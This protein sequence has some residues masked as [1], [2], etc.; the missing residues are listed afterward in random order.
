MEPSAAGKHAPALLALAAA[1]LFGLSAPLS[2]LLLAGIPP[3]FL[4]AFLYLGAGLGML[5]LPLLSRENRREAP[6]SSREVPWVILMVLLDV[7]APFLLLR[8]L[9]RTTAA[10]ASLLFNFETVAT[11]LVALL[12][13]HEAIGKRMWLSLGII[14]AASILLSIDFSHP[15]VWDFS[16]GSLLVL[17][18]CGCWGMENN[19]TR[20]MSAKSPAQIVVVKGVGAGGT[21]LVLAF[22]LDHPFPRSAAVIAPA[23]L[24]GFVSYGLS[25]FCYVKAQRYLGAVRTS[26]YYAAAPFIGVLLSMVI[27]KEIPSWNF[28]AAAA[29]MLWG[30]RLAFRENHVHRHRHDALAHNHMHLHDDLHHGHAH[31]PPVRG[32]H[33]HE[34]VH[35]PCIHTHPHTPDLHH[36]HRHGQ[37]AGDG[38]GATA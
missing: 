27:L 10:N 26:A 7:L 34:H 8:G 31:N 25:I 19:C 35:E 21:A 9:E 4:T 18:A 11:S 2:K 20:N 15:G 24:L 13:F 1:L 37:T 28:A 30:V 22:L 23:L 3:M 14:T 32:W 36:R 38:S 5:L 6:L 17:A 16:T 33:S 12:F 29:L